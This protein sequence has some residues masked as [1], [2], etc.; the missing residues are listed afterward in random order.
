MTD[1][2]ISSL[3]NI[4]QEFMYAA[5]PTQGSAGVT[6]QHRHPLAHKDYFSILNVSNKFEYQSNSSLKMFNISQES[7]YAAWPTQGRAGVTG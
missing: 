2:S 6:G 4:D 5:W 7:M 1:N 3:F